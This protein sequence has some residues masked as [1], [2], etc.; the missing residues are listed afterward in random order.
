MNASLLL[1]WFTDLGRNIKSGLSETGVIIFM[2]AFLAVAL[3]LFYGIIRSC[4][5]TIKP[6]MPWGYA[7]FL[8]IFILL[9][10]WFA[11][12]MGY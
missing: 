8:V 5:I 1:N 3:C 2:V 12:I 10:V 4:L 11:V 6:K 7:F 9:F